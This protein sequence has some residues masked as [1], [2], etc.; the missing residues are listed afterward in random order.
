MTNERCKYLISTL[1]IESSLDLPETWQ[2]LNTE[3]SLDL[4][5]TWHV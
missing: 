4:S 1:N 3:S 5:E 2:S